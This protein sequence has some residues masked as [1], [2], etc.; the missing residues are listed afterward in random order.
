MNLEIRLYLQ[1]LRRGWWL[2]LL[3]A[4]IALSASLSVSLLATPQ[5]KATARF[6][7]TPSAELTRG[8]DV[9]DSLDTLDRRSVVATYAEVMNSRRIF[10]NALN[11]LQLDAQE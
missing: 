2:I 8:K 11:S 10:A 1:M 5:Y 9:V 7:I 3:A 6:L 4:L